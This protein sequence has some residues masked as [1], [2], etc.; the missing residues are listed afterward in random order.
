LRWIN[1][2]LAKSVQTASMV[3]YPHQLSS[4]A[5][6]DTARKLPALAERHDLVTVPAAWPTGVSPLA[7]AVD[8]CQRSD[9]EQVSKD[10]L[11]RAQSNRAA[12]GF[13][14]D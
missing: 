1:A 8:A 11:A 14:P 10:W 3:L 12:A 6:A 9:S 4:P 2:E 13:V 5:Q 7:Q